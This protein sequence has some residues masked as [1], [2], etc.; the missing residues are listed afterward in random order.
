[1]EKLVDVVDVCKFFPFKRNI[2]EAVLRR[3]SRSVRAVDSVGFSMGKGET[4][5]VAGES[6]CGKTT[7]GKLLVR[8]YRPTSGQIRFE[9][10]DVAQLHGSR[11]KDYRRSSQMIFQNPYTAINP[12]FTIES[13]ITEPLTIHRIGSPK[14]RKTMTSDML[15]RVQLNP[16]EKFL[17]CFP[18]QL[19]GGERQRAVIARA[20]ILNPK[21]L[22][23]D[24]P[25][26]M[27]D[28]SVRAGALE[29]LERIAKEFNLTVM[30][31]SHDLS[32]LRYMCQRL[33]VMYLGKIV[34]SGRRC[35]SGAR[36]GL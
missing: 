35:G 23:A 3:P 36:S 4:L 16:P 18:H 12:R 29:L 24:E 25:A 15:E 19:S 8:L 21:F 30:Y 32:L 7:L 1:M 34:E 6:G 33:A 28:V 22:V 17:H 14:E 13:F 10:E 11:L 2:V 9:G 5:G 27:L 26:S 20:L 31:I